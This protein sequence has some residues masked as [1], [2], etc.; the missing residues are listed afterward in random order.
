MIPKL[1]KKIILGLVLIFLSTLLFSFTP[2]DSSYSTIYILRSSSW[3]S[4]GWTS[5]IHIENQSPFNLEPGGAVAFKIFSEGE[6]SIMARLNIQNNLFYC[7]LKIKRGNDYYVCLTAADL[8]EESKEYV[9]SFLADRTD[10]IVKLEENLDSPI[11]KKSLQNYNK[12]GQGTCFLISSEGFVI[13]NFH[14]VENAKT[15]TVKGIENDFV[16]KYGAVLVASDPSNDLA[17]L[18]I[19]NKNVK[20]SNP[21]F[22]IRSSGVLQAEKVF[23]LGYPEA[24]AMGEE[25]KITEGIISSRSG[26]NGDISKF[27]I[28]A[29]INHGNSGGPLIDENGNLIGVV[30]AKSALAESAGYAIKASYVETFLKNAD[31]F[32]Y[33]VP[34]N[35]FNQKTLPEKVSELKNFIFIIESD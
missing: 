2:P 28:S 32:N 10:K 4:S 23:V 8:K 9:K 22:G 31:G 33:L 19:L 3:N 11:N 6:V 15:I 18:K 34:V 1:Q 7:T 25:I 21:P 17:L 16:T 13:T 12:K 35:V 5:S 26:V 30:Y 14:C 27:Q 29:G 20:F 24:W